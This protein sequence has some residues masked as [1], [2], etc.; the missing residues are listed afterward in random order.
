MSLE[1]HLPK[2]PDSSNYMYIYIYIDCTLG[3]LSPLIADAVDASGHGLLVDGD[4]P[5]A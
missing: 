2:S 3:E 4:C 1:A 5:K